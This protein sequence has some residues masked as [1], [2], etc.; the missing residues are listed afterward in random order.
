[1]GVGRREEPGAEAAGP[2]SLVQAATAPVPARTSPP[3][4]NCRRENPFIMI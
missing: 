3:T 4:R 1:M 2:G